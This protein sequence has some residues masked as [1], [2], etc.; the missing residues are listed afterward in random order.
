MVCLS[1]VTI[2]N[3]YILPQVG[4]YWQL[5]QPNPINPL[6]F[7]HYFINRL[8]STILLAIT[9]ELN[10]ILPNTVEQAKISVGYLCQVMNFLREPRWPSSMYNTRYHERKT[11]VAM[12]TIDQLSTY[13]YV[14][15]DNHQNNIYDK[16]I[17]I[18]FPLRIEYLPIYGSSIRSWRLYTARQYIGIA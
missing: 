11:A 14:Y 10:M 15:V 2:S 7:K 5:S 4:G 16:E 17:M 9:L 18:L 12:E 1:T 8:E 3:E 13:I 6:M